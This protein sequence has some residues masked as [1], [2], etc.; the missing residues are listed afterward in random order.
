MNSDAKTF[1]DLRTEVQ[2]Y[3]FY[4]KCGGCV[5]FCS[6]DNLGTVDF[7]PDGMPLFADEE[8]CL[9]CGIC[10]LICPNIHELD[11]ELIWRF[12]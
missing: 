10:Y 3:N 4:G 5:S 7:S 12:S 8:K 2:R 6:A 1:H 11:D 9:R